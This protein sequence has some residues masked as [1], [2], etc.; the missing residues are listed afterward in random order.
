[1]PEIDSSSPELGGGDGEQTSSIQPD[2][3]NHVTQGGGRYGVTP[4]VPQGGS[5]A[6]LGAAFEQHAGRSP[7]FELLSSRIQQKRQAEQEKQS[8]EITPAVMHA[9]QDELAHIR[10]EKEAF[11]GK[12]LGT[13]GKGLVGAARGGA[14]GGLARRA[15]GG[16]LG[17]ARKA[18]F[19]GQR[20]YQAVG[21]AALGAGALGAAGLG[22]AAAR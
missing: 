15:A 14:K 22:A 9:F 6:T 8:M 7:F 18:G 16:A 10:M 5:V 4:K 3:F 17:L 11:V 2:T 1:M 21:G 13:L 20:A 19:K 12:A